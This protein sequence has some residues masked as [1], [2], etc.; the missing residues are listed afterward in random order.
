MYV[1]EKALPGSIQKSDAINAVNTFTV[2]GTQSSPRDIILYRYVSGPA[3]LAEKEVREMIS[4]GWQPWGHPRFSTVE[5]PYPIFV[6]TN[7]L[8]QAMVLYRDMV[9][10]VRPRTETPSEEKKGDVKHG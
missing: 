7:Y 9:G 3:E 5:T 1:D 2:E 6:T 10:R 8:E 4:D